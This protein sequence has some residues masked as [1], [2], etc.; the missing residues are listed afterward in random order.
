MFTTPQ[1]RELQRSLQNFIRS[2][3]NP[4]VEEWERA[5]ITPLHELMK[6]MGA[7]GLLGIDKPEAYGGMGLD[8]SYAMVASETLGEVDCGGV[9]LGI[10]VQT[11]MATPALARFGSHELKEQFLRP[12]VA[13][14]S[15]CSIAVSEVSGGSDVAAITTTA[16]RDGDDYVISGGKMW[17]TNATQADWVCL[18]ANTSDDS[19]HRNKSLI[20]VPTDLPGFSVSP[21]LE[22]LGMH[23]SDTAQVYLD[24][25]RV[26]QRYRVGEEGKGFSYQMMQFQEE[27]LSCISNLRPLEI[28][29]ERTI[30]Y[31]R[32]RLVFGKPILDNQVVHFRLAELQTEIEALRA[33]FY[34][35]AQQYIDG[36][37]VTQLASMAKLKIGRLTREVA[38]ACL[39]YW[40]GM[41]Y[42]WDNPVARLFRDG[43]LVSIG[44]G[45]DEIMLNIIA[46]NMG[47]LPDKKQ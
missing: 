32:Q 17:I 20:I 29:I 46:K 25:V 45:T 37:D 26:P 40:G 7:L 12:A 47:T 36:E 33:L 13:G 31:C 43:R 4:F 18:L 30:D 35:A 28:A 8:Y 21:R 14:E 39:Q 19:V 10:D 34:R 23:S 5:G 27:R 9:K 38:D 22:K 41:G 44:G 3:I 6:K 42:M 11:S 24:D 2:D 15:V 16:R 1:H